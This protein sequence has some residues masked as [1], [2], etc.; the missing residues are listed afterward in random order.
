[1]QVW[2][3]NADRFFPDAEA[4]IRWIDQPSLVPFLPW[5]PEGEK[6]HF[7]AG[8]V[9]RMLRATLRENGKYFERFRR[10]NVLARK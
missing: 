1:V 4:L 5:V 3:E 8:V 2:G 7:R 6:A 10:I 9:H